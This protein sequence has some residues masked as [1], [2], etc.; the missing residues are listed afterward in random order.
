MKPDFSMIQSRTM[1]VIKEDCKIEHEAWLLE[2]QKN[3]YDDKT[4]INE[5]FRLAK[6][7]AYKQC[8]LVFIKNWKPGFSQKQ[9]TKYWVKMMQYAN[10]TFDWLC[11]H[12]W[13]S[14][15]ASY[16][17]H[18]ITYKIMEDLVETD[19][20]PWIEKQHLVSCESI[21]EHITKDFDNLY[22]VVYT[23]SC[24]NEVDEILKTEKQPMKVLH[25]TFVTLLQQ[26]CGQLFNGEIE[27]KA[28]MNMFYQY[29]LKFDHDKESLVQFIQTNKHLL[30]AKFADANVKRLKESSST[31]RKRNVDK[32]KTS[33][34]RRQ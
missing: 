23:N 15:F 20:I 13:T 12:Y 18:T 22:G 24:R 2:D 32:S 10:L 4:F 31:K 33:K 25:E 1:D 14:K 34:K 17:K 6:L 8:L 26:A 28:F 19:L 27:P 11:R 29:V 5:V 30:P 21:L 9:H 16:Y 7:K 3:K